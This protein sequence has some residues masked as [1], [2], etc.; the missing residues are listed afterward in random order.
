MIA[1]LWTRSTR[2]L[3][4]GFET[5]RDVEHSRLG[6]E[7]VD[8]R[9][10]AIFEVG[11]GAVELVDEA[12]PRHAVLVG[13]TPHRLGLRLN[14]GNAVETGNRAIEHAQRAFDFDGE[15]DVAGGVDDV[16][17]VVVPETGRRSR[18]D[19][20]PA[21]LLLLHPVHRRRA[22]MHFAD[23]VALAGV[24]E[25]ALG[26]RGLAGVDVRHDTD[27]A[28]HAERMAACHDLLSCRIDL[29]LPAVVQ[30]A[31]LA[32]AMRWVS[33]RFLTALPRLLAASSSSADSRADIVVSLR[34]R[35]AVISQRMASAWARSGRT[36][37]GT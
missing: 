7:A 8:D 1:R 14:P 29:R 11:A 36:S 3:E 26:G 25:D 30:N 18:G 28:V 4:V 10:H 37:T 20:D 22:I 15:V 13:L 27:I 16:D 2:P 35:A 31:R 5:D 34:L 19:R 32:S 17:A 24:I 21:F 9:L 33:S 12:H 6:A 23:L